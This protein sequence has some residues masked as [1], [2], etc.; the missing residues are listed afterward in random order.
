MVL[1][2]VVKSRRLSLCFIGLNPRFRAKNTAL[3]YQPTGERCEGV[4][5]YLDGTGVYLA[6]G[7]RQR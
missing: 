4:K 7:S 5:N 2:A 1:P 6:P 3:R